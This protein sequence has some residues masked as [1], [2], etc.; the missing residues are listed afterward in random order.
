MSP[1]NNVSRNSFHALVRFYFPEIFRGLLITLSHLLRNLFRPEKMPVVSYPEEQRAVPAGYRGQ[2]RLTKRDDGT[3]RCTACFLCATACPAKCI[4]IE[5]GELTDKSREKYPVRYE[6]DEL[7]CVMCG[8]C[9]EACPCDAIRMDTGIVIQ[10]AERR[11]ALLFDKEH[12]GGLEG[13][14]NSPLQ[15]PA[16]GVNPRHQGSAIQ[17][18][19][20]H[21]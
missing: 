12:L 15:T 7:R 9:V 13:V 3:L 10:T 19:K 18:R 21:E 5:A 8:L 11:R 14:E 17:G 6:I 1:S 16:Q 4:H 20:S 2:H